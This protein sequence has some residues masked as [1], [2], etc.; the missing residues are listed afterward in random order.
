MKAVTKNEAIKLINDGRYI[1][2]VHPWYGSLDE[3]ADTEHCEKHEEPGFMLMD[4][5]DLYRLYR[6]EMREKENALARIHAIRE[7]LR[8]I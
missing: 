6:N 1:F 7:K 8:M 5:H 3:I 2:W 4:E